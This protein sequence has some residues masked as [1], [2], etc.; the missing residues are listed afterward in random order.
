MLKRT[1]GLRSHVNTGGLRSHVKTGTFASVSRKIVHKVAELLLTA[2]LLISAFCVAA[3][4]NIVSSHFRHAGNGP[5]SATP[6]ACGPLHTQGTQIKNA[7]GQTVVLTGV[8]WSGFETLS[9]APHGLDVRNYQNMLDQM[10]HLGFNTL[11]LPYSNQLFDPTS[12]PTGINYTL[13]PD[14]RGLQGLALIDKIIAGAQ[15][16]GLCV[17]LDQHRPDAYDQSILWYTPQMPQS[18]WIHEWVMLAQ[19][20]KNNPTVIGADLH[21][22]PE[23]TATWGDGNPATDWRLAAEQAGNAVLAVNP[24]W[25]V[26]VEGI[27]IYKGDRYWW[28][29]NLEGAKQYPVQLSVAHQLVYSAHDYGPE[30]YDMNWFQ[31]PAFPKNMPGIWRKHWAYLQQDGIAPVILG[32]FGDTSVGMDPDGLWQRAMAA[33]IAQNGFS[34]IYWSWSPNTQDNSGL[35]ENDWTTVD[36]SKLAILPE[37][38]ATSPAV[39]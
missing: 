27:A 18:R 22:E 21:N 38:R 34:Y 13:N 26:I 37:L 9:F 5:T 33:Y 25:L 2:F 20:Y 16:A 35:L 24:H 7:A 32:E 23:Q 28:G 39:K 10:V 14:L 3:P 4:A 30:V 8:N 31:I 15:K 17:I 36:R 19:H 1:I 29:G 6:R 12:L 11:R